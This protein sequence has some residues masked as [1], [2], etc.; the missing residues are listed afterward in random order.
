LSTVTEFKNDGKIPFILKNILKKSFR[1]DLQTMRPFKRGF[2]LFNFTFLC[3]SAKSVPQFFERKTRNNYRKIPFD[4]T[5]VTGR[6]D[7]A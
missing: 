2:I 1:K 4:I 5:G 6:T 7:R 3:I